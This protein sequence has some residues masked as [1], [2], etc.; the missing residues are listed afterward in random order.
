MMAERPCIMTLF[1]NGDNVGKAFLQK[2]ATELTENN[3]AVDLDKDFEIP[4]H[5]TDEWV[6]VLRD[7][8][9]GRFQRCPWCGSIFPKSNKGETGKIYCRAACKTYASRHRTAQD[10]HDKMDK[11]FES[12]VSA[13]A[14]KFGADDELLQKT[15]DMRAAYAEQHVKARLE[16]VVQSYDRESG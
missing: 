9:R 14:E 3:V 8:F 4:R 6:Q 5:L 16:N 2:M 12:L 10:R 11:K 1:I 7:F 15:K 13:M